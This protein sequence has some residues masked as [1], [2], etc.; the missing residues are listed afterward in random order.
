MDCPAS[1]HRVRPDGEVVAVGGHQAFRYRTATPAHTYHSVV[2]AVGGRLVELTARDSFDE[3]LAVFLLDTVAGLTLP[4]PRSRFIRVFPADFPVPWSFSAVVVVPPVV[5]RRFEHE[6]PALRRI[7]Y[8]SVP[9]FDGEFADRTDG[10]AFWHQIRRK[11]GWRSVV[12]R[13][14]R[15]P[16]SR[17]VFDA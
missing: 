3:Q 17:P 2:A 10:A 13:W 6:S 16:K 4:G 14:D 5:A 7:V 15:S 11:D 9:A 8:W 12:V 1:L